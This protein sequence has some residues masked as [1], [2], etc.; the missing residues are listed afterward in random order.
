MTLP[1][2]YSSLLL[3]PPQ[4]LAHFIPKNGIPWNIVSYKPSQDG[5]VKYKQPVKY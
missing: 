3:P 4:A 5:K 2:N 1:L